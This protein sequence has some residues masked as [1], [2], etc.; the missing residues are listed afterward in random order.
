MT[1]KL[2]HGRMGRVRNV[3]HLT[4]NVIVKIRMKH[5]TIAKRI[6]MRIEHMKPSKCQQDFHQ[7]IIECS[8]LKVEA[9][10]KG[11]RVCLKRQHT[12]PVKKHFVSISKNKLRQ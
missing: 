11:V 12:G 9:K 8:K 1:P 5:R 4:V 10:N 6:N 2:Y 3:T 7:I